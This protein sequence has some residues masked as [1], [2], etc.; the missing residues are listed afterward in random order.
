MPLHRLAPGVVLLSVVLAAG[1]LARAWGADGHRVI[2][3]LAWR[4]IAPLTREAILEIQ[5]AGGREAFVSGCNWAD[6]VKDENGHAWSRPWHY[7]DTRARDGEPEMARDC[8]ANGCA[9]SAIVEMVAILRDSTE[10]GR[11][12][13]AEALRFLTHLTGDL[14]QPLHTGNA[15]DLGGNTIH[16][17]FL[18]EPAT[19][20]QVWDSGILRASGESWRDLASRLH[21]SLPARGGLALDPTAW[22]RESSRLARR[23][24]YDL[25]DG[26]DLGATYARRHRPL[27]ERQ[28]AR[29]AVR[30]A[31]LLDRSLARGP[32]DPPPFWTGSRRGSVVHY[33]ECADARSITTRNLVIF[34]RRP[35]ERRLHRGC[36]R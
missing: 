18:G 2:C 5:S 34:E 4:E 27:V 32:G 13:R 15:D 36:P 24:A 7:I 21:R 28:L 30:L 8:P 12:S 31:A 19:L 9:I 26:R 29:A 20:H 10:E 3:D 17:T 25:R 6:Q 1:P 11:I 35:A 16:V 23:H 22:A 14:H 33:P